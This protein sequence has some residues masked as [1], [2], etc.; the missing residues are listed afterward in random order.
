VRRLGEQKAH[1]KYD[2]DFG[3]LGRL[4]GMFLPLP[5]QVEDDPADIAVIVRL[6]EAGLTGISIINPGS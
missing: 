3:Q 4:S 5:A 2:W 6:R 1:Y